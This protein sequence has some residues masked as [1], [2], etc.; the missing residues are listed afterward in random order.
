MGSQVI[1]LFILASQIYNSPFLD[2]K[3]GDLKTWA[4]SSFIP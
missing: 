1:L 2:M 3:D 4:E